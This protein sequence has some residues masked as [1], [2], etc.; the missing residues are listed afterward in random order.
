MKKKVIHF[1]VL[2][3]TLSRVKTRRL[4]ASFTFTNTF[5]LFLIGMHY[6][7]LI[8]SLASNESLTKLRHS[9]VLN[10]KEKTIQLLYS[11]KN[12]RLGF[13]SSPS[14]LL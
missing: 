4:S 7:T 1:Q 11:Y 6:W 9:L 5:D 10:L 13:Q 8:F 2:S 12:D 3:S 14:Q